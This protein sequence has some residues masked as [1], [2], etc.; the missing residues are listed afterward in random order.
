MTLALP[1]TGLIPQK[2]GTLILA[3]IGIPKKV[4]GKL[5][6]S[7]ENVFGKE[8]LVKLFPL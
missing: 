5:G 1:K 8:F 4:Y 2:T 6:I 7:L 3:D